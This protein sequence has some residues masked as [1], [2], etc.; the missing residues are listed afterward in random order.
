MSRYGI[1]SNITTRL[2]YTITSIDGKSDLA[3]I[4]KFVSS[5][6]VS[7]DSV[8][9]RNYIRDI[10]PELDTTFNFT[11][12]QCGAVTRME[13]PMTAEFFWPSR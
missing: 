7:R 8:A 4:A 13:L 3:S 10:T 1:A 6:M 5:E 12:P 2:K 11:C 9:L